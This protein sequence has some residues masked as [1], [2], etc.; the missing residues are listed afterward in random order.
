MNGTLDL[1]SIDFY[2]ISKE[3]NPEF[4]DQLMRLFEHPGEEQSFLHLTL[5]DQEDR[6]RFVVI[7]TRLN[8]VVVDQNSNG[9]RIIFSGTTSQGFTASGWYSND[10]PSDRIGGINFLLKP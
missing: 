2:P 8:T 1:R 9:R 3:L 10:P 5:Q 4:Y 7:L 6:H